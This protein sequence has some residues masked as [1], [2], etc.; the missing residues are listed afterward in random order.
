M[1]AERELALVEDLEPLG[2][3][4]HQPVLDAVVDHLHEVPGAAGPHVT[5]RVG[6]GEGVEDRA[7]AVDVV[8]QPADHH[9]I[10]FR[11]P[12]DAAA[13]AHVEETDL[14]LGKPFGAPDGIFVVAV[15][16][17]DE[18]I[19]VFQ[20]LSELTHDRLG[21]IARRYHDPH[22]LWRRKA[23]DHLFDGVDDRD[24]VDPG[25]VRVRVTGVADDAVAALHATVGRAD[26]EAQRHIAAHF[27]EPD[28]AAL[29]AAA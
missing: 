8:L 3:R 27:P 9:A 19:A 15:P 14:S 17:V 2:V 16:A 6:L 20:Q 26:C 11:A 5:P 23:P 12:P 25:E 22:D 10:P 24:P 4:L 28:A 29:H 7:D 1:E 18:E 13:R 21:R